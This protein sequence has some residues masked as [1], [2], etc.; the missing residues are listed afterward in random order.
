MHIPDGFL[1]VYVIIPTLIITL[2]F[3]TIS[4]KK[5]KLTEPQVPIMGLLTAL[6]F[7][8]MMMNYPSSAEQPPT[9]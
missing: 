4:V 8:A 1:S 2:I 5:A 6:F 7:A 3:W 9:Y